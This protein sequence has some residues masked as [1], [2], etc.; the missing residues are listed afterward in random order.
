M[1]TVDIVPLTPEH[2]ALLAP[3]VRPGDAAELA[4]LGLRPEE[5]ASAAL[6]AS[7]EAWA[8]VEDDKVLAAWGL[9]PMALLGDVANLWCITA[10]GIERHKKRFLSNSRDFVLQANERYGVLRAVVALNYE[11]ATRWLAWL[12]FETKER[13]TSEGQTF[14][15]MTR[16]RD[17][18]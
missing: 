8:A 18:H 4:A 1:R 10:K 9:H 17:G 6:A 5:A 7:S 13:F 12:G 16:V 14:L 11:Q 15:R 3:H 2:I